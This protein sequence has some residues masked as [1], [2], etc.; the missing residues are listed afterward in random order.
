MMVKMVF[1]NFMDDERKKLFIMGR[2]TVLKGMA[3][4]DQTDLLV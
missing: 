1:A 3:W 2:M 4:S